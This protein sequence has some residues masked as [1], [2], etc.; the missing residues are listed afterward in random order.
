[1][2]FLVTIPTT[3]NRERKVSQD[4]VNKIR[5]LSVE[6][7]AIFGHL[8]I[9]LFTVAQRDAFTSNRIRFQLSGLPS[10]VRNVPEESRR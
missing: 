3:C 2:S 4:I 6:N 9:L 7:K 10:S 1:M 5:L 8:V